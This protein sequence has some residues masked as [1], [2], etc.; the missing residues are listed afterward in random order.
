MNLIKLYVSIYK[1]RKYAVEDTD[2][3]NYLSG[4]YINDGTEPEDRILSSVEINGLIWH[5]LFAIVFLS[6]FILQIIMEF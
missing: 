3:D 4:T 2:Y 1:T 6:L 5:K